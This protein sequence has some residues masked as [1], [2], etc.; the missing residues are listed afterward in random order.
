MLTLTKLFYFGSRRNA[1]ISERCSTFLILKSDF[2][3]TLKFFLVLPSS[4][5]RL[6][7]YVLIEI[8]KK[9]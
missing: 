4:E 2:S 6:F 5:F 9:K 8:H 3:T 7:I 1:V